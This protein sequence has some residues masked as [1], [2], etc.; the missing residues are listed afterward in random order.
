MTMRVWVRDNLAAPAKRVLAPMEVRRYLSR[1]DE[2]RLNIGCGGNRLPG[3]LNV[4]RFPPFGVTFMD[5]TTRL[6]FDDGTFAAVLC[7]HMI[8]HVPKSDAIHLLGELARILAPGGAVRIVTPDLGWLAS[9]V[10]APVPDGAPDETYRTFLSERHGGTP[11]SWC[12]AINLCFYEHSHCY[13]WS[14]EELSEQM[15]SA[16]FKDLA[17]M[18]AGASKDPQFENVDGHPRLIGELVNSLEAFAIEARV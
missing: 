7:E 14:I 16:G 2:P 6:P 4:D 11:V 10:L 3:W 5:A 1:H 17:V 18:R 12:D 15:Q 8:E 9:R 13:I